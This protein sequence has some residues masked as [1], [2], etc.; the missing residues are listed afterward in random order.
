MLLIGVVLRRTMAG[1]NLRSCLQADF[2]RKLQRD[3]LLELL[4]R[5]RPELVDHGFVFPQNDADEIDH[6]SLTGILAEPSDELGLL[7]EAIYLIANVGTAERFD[8]L[9]DIAGK[10]SVDVAN[11][12][13]TAPDRDADGPLSR[14]DS[15]QQDH[16][17][18]RLDL[19]PG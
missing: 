12:K 18:R 5:S 4:L 3:V 7:I 8:E 1:R 10:K 9:L 6:K 2:L 13:V 16:Q 19:L 14:M 15:R 17:A 11:L